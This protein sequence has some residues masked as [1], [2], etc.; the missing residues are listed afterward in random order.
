MK[1][2]APRHRRIGDRAT[3]RKARL[4]ARRPAPGNERSVA[5]A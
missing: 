1:R 4:H 3:R 5:L 2:A